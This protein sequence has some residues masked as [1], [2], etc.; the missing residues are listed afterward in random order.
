MSSASPLEAIAWVTAQLGPPTGALEIRT[1]EVGLPG[2]NQVR[3]QTEAFCL[4]FNDIDTI[5]GRYGLLK[6]DPP[7]TPGMAAAGLVDAV[8]P[9]AEG[10]LGRRVVGTSDGAKGAYASAVLLNAASVQTLPSWL[11]CVDAMAMYFPYMLGWLALRERARIEPNDVVLVHAGAG[12]VG[13]GVVQL[14]KAFGAIVIATAGSDDKVGFCRQLGADFAVNYRTEDFVSYV[15]DVTNGRG[16]DI[17][18]DSVGG[19]VTLGTFK[20]MAFNGRHLIIGYAADIA[21]EEQPVNLQPSIYGNF[22]ISGVCFA[23]VDDPR[24]ARM[25]GMNFLTRS[26]GIRIWGEVLRMNQRGQIRPVVGRQID[27]ADVPEMLEAME[28]RET[29]GRTVVAAPRP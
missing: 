27:F 21:L 23:F 9:G 7:F 6:F 28:R 19:Q 11:S 20:S 22:D 5:Y 25:L 2:P 18:F 13:S 16:V 4:D 24:P 8:G 12:G 15:D 1:V 14:A 29:M 17:A 10:L 26:D 3:V